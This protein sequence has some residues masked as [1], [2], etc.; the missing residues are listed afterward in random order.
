[1]GTSGWYAVPRADGARETARGER[2]DGQRGP[3][4]VTEQHCETGGVEEQEEDQGRSAGRSGVPSAHDGQGPV[5]VVAGIGVV[6]IGMGI[7]I[8]T[9]EFTQLN[10]TVNHWLQTLGL[11]DFNSD[12]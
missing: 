9:G 7:L 4:G 3:R 10:I 2:H 1:M 5:A 11:P 6:L 12:T 8:W